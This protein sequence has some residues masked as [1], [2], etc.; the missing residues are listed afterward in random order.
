MA[1]ITLFDYPDKPKLTCVIISPPSEPSHNL[2]HHYG[3]IHAPQTGALSSTT[4]DLILQTVREMRDS[5]VV[6]SWQ[7][8]LS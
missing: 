3:I 1:Y 8:L 6:R 2:Q 7:G 5:R 4:A